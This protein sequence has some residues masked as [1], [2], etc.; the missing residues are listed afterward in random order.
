MKRLLELWT[1]RRRPASYALYVAMAGTAALS[2]VANIYLAKMVD[3]AEFGRYSLALATAT[4]VGMFADIGYF[5]S[6]ARLLTVVEHETEKRR[7][8]GATL[9]VAAI[10]SGVLAALLLLVSRVAGAIYGPDI[11]ALLQSTVVMSPAFVLPFAI[12]QVLKALQR[13]S[14]LGLWHFGSRIAFLGALVSLSA[15]GNLNAAT[16]LIANLGSTVLALLVVVFALRPVF[17]EVGQRWDEI[18]REHH[19][20]GRPLYVGKIIAST[21]YHSD[22]LL[23]GFFRDA[24]AVG[25]YAL[26]MGF[27]NAVAM[28]SSALASQSFRDFSRRRPL[29][30]GLQRQNLLGL[31]ALGSAGFGAAALIVWGYMG[32]SYGAVVTI[33]IPALFVSWFQGAYQPYNSWLLANGLGVEI[34]RALLLMTIVNTVANLALIP[35]FGAVGAALASVCSVLTYLVLARREYHRFVA[36]E[37]TGDVETAPGVV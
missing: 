9:A 35:L 23:L 32:P 10:S 5:S 25:H 17:R 30:V 2:L 26:A 31:V 3:A 7:Y 16:A 13:V 22:R 19:R 14:M 11:G 15:A 24:T 6:G 33:L 29:P 4:F 20:F 37:R 18:R 12:D 27:A 36:R 28:F 34:R 8:V 21:T 1:R